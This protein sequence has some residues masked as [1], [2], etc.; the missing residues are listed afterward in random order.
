M[1][2]QELIDQVAERAELSKAVAGKVVQAFMD[3]VQKA[4]EKEEAVRLVGFGSF[5][6]HER[7]AKE[8]R[9]PKTGEPLLIPSATNVKL[10]PGSKLK[11]AVNQSQHG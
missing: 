5:T 4:L 3:A 10:K 2:K 1:N 8:G 11:E 7:A 9:N 6:T